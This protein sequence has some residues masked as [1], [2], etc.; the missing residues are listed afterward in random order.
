MALIATDTYRLSNWLKSEY[1]PELAFCRA[2]VT[3]N[4][5]E[6]TLATGTVLG[7]V[8]A[9]GKYKVCVQT[10]VDGSQT[11]DAIVMDAVTIPATIDTKVLVLLRGPATVS[12][13]IV[14][15]ASHDLDAE[16]LA[17]YTALEAKN[18]QVLDVV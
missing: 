2:V 12:K 11:A 1:A 3:V 4:D 17:I 18:I 14:L 16:K 5:S 6:Q 7:K 8:T 9:T 15:H 13:N 10:A